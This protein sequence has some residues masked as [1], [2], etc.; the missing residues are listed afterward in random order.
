MMNDQAGQEQPQG[1]D[2]QF[3][4]PAGEPA[5]QQTEQGADQT[6]EAWPDDPAALIAL[7]EE[8]RARSEAAR[9][10]LLRA[11][12][13]VENIS[14]RKAKELENAHKFALENFV[15]ELLQVRDSLELGQAA[16]SEPDADLVKLR[17]G[18]DLTLKLLGDVMGKFGVEQVNPMHQPFNPE[19]HQAMSMQPRADVDPNTVVAVIQRGYTLNGRLVRPALVMVSQ[20]IEQG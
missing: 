16:A 18:M 1:P 17:E 8:E 3:E 13:E 10:Q 4:T 11:R 12:A 19:F 9:D 6:G 7:I 14:R 15:R 2:E 20:A 5:S